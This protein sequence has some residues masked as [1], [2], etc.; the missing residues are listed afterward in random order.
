MADYWLPALVTLLVWWAST[1]LIIYLDGLR[2]ET[3][4]WT[5][6]GATS[7]LL[8]ALT[9]LHSVAWDTSAMGAWLAF[10][11]GLVAWAWIEIA[12]LTGLVTGPRRE[13]IPRG[14]R[15]WPRFR[16]AVAAILWHE[17]AI[18]VMAGV[19]VALSWGA[20]NQIGTWT[21]V[22][23]WVMRQ[24]AKLNVFLGVRNLSESFLPDHLRYLESYFKR[25]PMNLLF[26]VS[27]LAGLVGVV[28][29]ALAALDP[30]ASRHETI[31]FT[32]LATLVALGL[33]EHVFMVL[34]VPADGLWKWSLGSRAEAVRIAP[35]PAREE[36]RPRPSSAA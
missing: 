28:L 14:T 13:A 36:G 7:L 12:F 20:P 10:A 11:C 22:A 6:L 26:P 27:I 9:G 25:R 16:A 32:L 1:G 30:A 4:R 15:G 5:M 34:P 31:G 35:V 8:V 21:F 2:R 18:V 23:F 33:L 24:S 19:I 29:L 17:L 3:F